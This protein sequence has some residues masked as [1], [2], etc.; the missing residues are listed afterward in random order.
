LSASPF[1]RLPLVTLALSPSVPDDWQRVERGLGAP[2]GVGDH[3]DR[4]V[5]HLHDL[6]NAGPARDFGLIEALHLAAEYRAVLD[7]GAQHAGQLDVDG[8]GLAAVE[9]V[10]GVEPL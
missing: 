8:I 4:G 7:G 5:L 1:C 9:L 10:G 6:A 2:P 3:G